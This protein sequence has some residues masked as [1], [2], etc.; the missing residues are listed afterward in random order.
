MHNSNLLHVLTESTTAKI[1]KG[2]K[3]TPQMREGMKI[4][5]AVLQSSSPGCSPAFTVQTDLFWI[6]KWFWITDPQAADAKSNYS[7][8]YVVTQSMSVYR[9][10]YGSNIFQR[11]KRSELE[12]WRFLVGCS[13]IFWEMTGIFMK[14]CNFTDS[15]QTCRLLILLLVGILIV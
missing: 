8:M 3:Q 15:Q 10:M 6:Y 1:S 14:W 7:W 12:W 13:C 11:R 5:G 2:V 9:N 4:F